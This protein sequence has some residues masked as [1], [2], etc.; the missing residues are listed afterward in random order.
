[1]DLLAGSRGSLAAGGRYAD[2]ERYARESLAAAQAANLSDSDPRLAN[3]WEQL[4][5]TLCAE[6]KTDDGVRA[7]KIAEAIYGRAG[8]VWIPTAERVRKMIAQ[9]RVSAPPEK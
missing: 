6:K 7:L 3:S 8:G 2:S 9:I 5:R 1:M 4:G